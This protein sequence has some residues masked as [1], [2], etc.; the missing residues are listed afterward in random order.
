MSATK[1]KLYELQQG[2]KFY[3]AHNN[4]IYV[5]IE[6]DHDEN[7]PDWIQYKAKQFRTGAL[8]NKTI[9]GKNARDMQYYRYTGRDKSSFLA[10]F[11]A[12][13]RICIAHM[14]KFDI[15]NA[16]L[17]N[18]VEEYIIMMKSYKEWKR[19]IEL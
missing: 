8:V 1:V 7:N 18:P 11:R 19:N 6:C 2:E 13:M 4:L 14:G 17:E 15:E 3:D 5:M 16:G 10:G 12:A 9:N